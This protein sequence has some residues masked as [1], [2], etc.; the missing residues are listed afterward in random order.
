[1][2]TVAQCCIYFLPGRIYL[3]CN[4]TFCFLNISPGP[5][6]YRNLFEN[7]ITRQMPNGSADPLQIFS[8]WCTSVGPSIKC[9]GCFQV[10]R[11]RRD[12]L[13]LQCSILVRCACC[14][15]FSHQ[16]PTRLCCSETGHSDFWMVQHC[17]RCTQLLTG[18]YILSDCL[19]L[20]WD[21]WGARQH[22]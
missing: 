11:A 9:A 20:S 4:C 10:P 18:R 8:S 16:A 7:A 22:L 21:L 6:Y 13:D 3:T 19:H 2:W 5:I 1:M 15:I 12:G 14:C 17:W